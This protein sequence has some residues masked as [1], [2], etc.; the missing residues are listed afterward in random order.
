[1]MRRQGAGLVAAALVDTDGRVSAFKD[2]AAA[3]AAAAR[4]APRRVHLRALRLRMMSCAFFL[5]DLE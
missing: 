1:M 3:A 5:S 4:R 2:S